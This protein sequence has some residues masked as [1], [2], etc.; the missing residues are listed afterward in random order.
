MSSVKTRGKQ[1]GFLCFT[2]TVD[3]RHSGLK[4]LFKFP[5]K[6][7][8]II[9]VLPRSHSPPSHPPSNDRLRPPTPPRDP[10]AKTRK[11]EGPSPPCRILNQKTKEISSRPEPANR[12]SSDRLY[13]LQ[14]T[15][16]RPTIIYS[17]TSCTT[18]VIPLDRS[19]CSNS[20]VNFATVENSAWDRY[21]S[22]NTD[23]DK[24]IILYRDAFRSY[25]YT[26]LVKDVSIQ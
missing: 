8:T 12:G 10:A 25:I 15:V 5:T 16:G 23:E 22:L 14:E 21:R 4:R 6:L 3:Q 18:A 24:T 2:E 1:S 13:T 19:L 20:A 7:H 17:S 11:T 26:C 9:I